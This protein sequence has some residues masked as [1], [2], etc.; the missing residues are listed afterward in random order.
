MYSTESE[1]ILDFLKGS[2]EAYTLLYEKYIDDLFSYGKAIT[3][4]VEQVKDA[5]QDVFY[6]ILSNRKLLQNVQNLKCFLFISLKNRIIDMNRKAT[7]ISSEDLSIS[8]FTVTNLTILDDL[9]EEEDRK[10]ICERVKKLLNE[11][12]S[13]QRGAVCLRYIYNMKYGEIADILNMQNEKSARNLVSRAI[14][15][16]RSENPSIILLLQLLHFGL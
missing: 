11:L 14:E 5:I 12:T 1:I 9:I 15:K 10:E 7:T 3:S 2:D 6:K 16:L 13:R 8:N 4:D